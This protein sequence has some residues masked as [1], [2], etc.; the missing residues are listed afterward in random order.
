MNFHH[1]HRLTGINCIQ[2]YASTI[3][4]LL[5]FGVSTSLALNL[6]YGAFGLIFTLFWVTIIDKLG[7]RPALI[8]SSLLAGS[9]LLVQA[10]LS[11]VYLNKEEVPVNALRAQVAMFYIFNLGFVCVGM[12]AWLIPAEMMPYN[13]R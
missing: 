4:G 11:Q 9:A 2:Y 13:I 12:L 6:L 3:F 1:L 8:F 7:R 5:G 10:V